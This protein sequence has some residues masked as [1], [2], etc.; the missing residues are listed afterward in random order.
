L[1]SVGISLSFFGI[2][3]S[4]LI[5]VVVAMAFTGVVAAIT[6][7]LVYK[8]LNT[9][10]SLMIT[11]IGVAFVYRSVIQ[12]YFGRIIQSYDL[13]RRGPINEIE[14]VAGITI[15]PRDLVILIISFVLV[16]GLH[17]LL[18]HTTLGRKMRAT[19]DNHSLAKVSGIRTDD[20]LKKTWFIGTALAAAGGI[21]LAVSTRLFP[22]LGFGFLLLTFAAVILGGIGSVYGAMLGGFIIGMVHELTPLLSGIGIGAEY[23]EVLAFSIMILV[24]LIRPQGIAGGDTL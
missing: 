17:I 8:P 14:Q 16:I 6:H 20:V 5:A 9:V 1:N 23:A 13:A 21:F 24:L 4:F 19:S 15:T 12:M 3:I 7:V 2:P 11:S 18:Q 10:F 22:R